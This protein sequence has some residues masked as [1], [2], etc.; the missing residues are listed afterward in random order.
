M[1]NI[2]AYFDL[3]DN[4]LPCKYDL[5]QIYLPM[6]MYAGGLGRRQRLTI[7]PFTA[8]GDAASPAMVP[9]LVRLPRERK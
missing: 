8:K 4:G 1:V 2:F 5:P 3:C 6:N 7:A 9:T